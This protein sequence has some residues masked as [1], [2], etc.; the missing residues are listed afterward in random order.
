[1]KSMHL[2]CGKIAAFLEKNLWEMRY[3]RYRKMYHLDASFSFNGY[4]V[5]FYGDGEIKAGSMS[6]IGRYSSILSVAGCRVTIGK[7]VMISHF[8]KM[9]TE[10]SEADQDFS[11]RELNT[12]NIKKYSGDIVIKDYAWIGSS[13]FIN[14][15]I[16]IGS[17]SVIG[18][19][20]V[21]TRN[22]PDNCIAAGAPA[23]IIK[24][25]TI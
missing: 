25:K 12:I 11:L 21:V 19:N 13:V 9:Y 7:Y 6:Y 16:T 4:G 14:P 2:F 20:S 10:S 3:D 18:A 1:M 17:N 5:D 24:Y 8:V 15:G 22:I 23:R